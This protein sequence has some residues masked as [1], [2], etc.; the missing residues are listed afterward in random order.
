MFFLQVPDEIFSLYERVTKLDSAIQRDKDDTIKLI[1]SRDEYEQTLV[2]YED[3]IGAADKFLATK[4][5]ALDLS[6]LSEEI[7]RQKKFFVNLA[8]CL[9]VLASLEEQFSPQV[10][11]FFFELKKHH[12]IFLR[13]E[14]TT[15]SNT[16]P[17]MHAARQ[18]WKG[19][20][21]TSTDW[22]RHTLSGLIFPSGRM[23]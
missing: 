20:L 13:F 7:A 16:P 4:V 2:E 11:F 21:V 8:H 14:N 1:I 15:K 17:F 19:A 3:I 22:R 18:S 12:E 9:Q 10:K 5:R 6:R 23:T